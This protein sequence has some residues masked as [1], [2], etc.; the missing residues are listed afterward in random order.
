[1]ICTTAPASTATAIE[2]V[3]SALLIPR[4]QDPPSTGQTSINVPATG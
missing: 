1:V 2:N 4:V 3:P